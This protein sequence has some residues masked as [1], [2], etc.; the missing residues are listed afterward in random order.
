[1]KIIENL[2]VQTKISKY[3][4]LLKKN[5]P[6]KQTIVGFPKFLSFFLL[7]S[8]SV[9]FLFFFWTSKNRAK[10]ALHCTSASYNSIFH[11]LIRSLIRNFTPVR[12]EL[13]QIGARLI[14]HEGLKS[15]HVLKKV[16]GSDRFWRIRCFSC[17]RND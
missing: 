12:P 2:K 8:M 10:R 9:L 15:L 5:D 1:M 11:L 3:F 16:L 13:P 4:S 7:E 14:F 17:Q 6:N